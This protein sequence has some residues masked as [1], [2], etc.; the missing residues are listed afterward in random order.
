MAGDLVRNKAV[1]TSKHGDDQVQSFLNIYVSNEEQKPKQAWLCAA[2]P[3]SQ[4]SPEPLLCLTEASSPGSSL[5]CRSHF[6][7]QI[8]GIFCIRQLLFNKGLTSTV[9]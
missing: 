4:S 6:A 3:R 8:Y 1:L 7:F 9:N 2:L 5:K